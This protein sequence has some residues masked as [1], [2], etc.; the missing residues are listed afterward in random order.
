MLQK[1]RFILFACY[2]LGV[3]F[4]FFPAIIHAQNPESNLVTT[5]E[6]IEYDALRNREEIRSLSA[7]VHDIRSQ[8][9]RI[10]Q[11]GAGALVL[12]LTAVFCAVWA[13][14]TG[15][16]AVLWFSLG[17]L[18]HIIALFVLLWKNAPGNRER[19]VA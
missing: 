6:K 18:F 14:N 9:S 7:R 4:A 2:L 15:R 13:Q 12:L 19:R 10:A 17:L 16:S 1:V 8:V 3:Y 11:D 5:L